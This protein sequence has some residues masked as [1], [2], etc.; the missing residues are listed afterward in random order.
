MSAG[1]RWEHDFAGAVAVPDEALWGAQTQR[2]RDAFTMS[3]L[4]LPSSYVHVLGSLKRAAALANDELGLLDPVIAGAV[5]RAAGEVASGRHDSQ[6]DIDL[7]QT[8]SGTNMN[9]NAN[10]VIANRANQILGH[11]LGG[12][13][14]VHPN[15]HVNLGQ[16]SNDVTPTVIHVAALVEIERRLVPALERLLESLRATAQRTAGVV[17]TGRTH[18]QDAVPIRLG[19]EFDGYAGQ[20]KRGLRRLRAAAEGLAEVALGGTAI[21]TGLNTHPAFA[22]LTLGHLSREYGVEVRETDGHFQAQN[23]VDEVVFASGALRTI[24]VSILKIAEDIRWMVSGPQ[25][26]FAEITVDPLGM[27]SSIM[28][29]KTNPVIAEATLQVVA[30]VLGNDATIA[31]ASG[32]GNFEIIVTSPVVAHA[33]LES[34]D[35]LAGAS[36]VL[37]ERCIDSVEPTER[38]PQQVQRVAMLA[39][40]LSP[41]VGYERAA[42]IMKAAATSGRAVL[43]VAREELDIP[44]D[45]LRRVLDP[46]SMAGWHGFA[47]GDERGFMSAHVEDAAR[48]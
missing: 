12:K 33:L 8:G 20:I 1:V 38:G 3:S 30:K 22:T 15:D 42:E 5:V 45:I 25:A 32:R 13:H 24:A 31:A 21:G 36:T 17:K 29:G 27:G 10:E 14:P 40:A 39:T 19:Q 18:L 34:I 4:R 47:P 35:I 11:P 23:T 7:F 28:P 16:S 41:L 2:A 48:A 6:F 26:G 37:A 44:D 46:A 9:M 43:D